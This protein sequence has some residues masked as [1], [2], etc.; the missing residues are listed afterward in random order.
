MKPIRILQVMTSMN[1]GGA[2]TYVMN[3]YRNINKQKV[4][5]DFVLHTDEEC[6]YN[7]EIRS[8]GGR[9]F[10]IPRYNG[11]NHFEYIKAWDTFF[12]E[13]S[14]YKVVHAH[15]RSTASIILKYAKK[16]NCITISHSHSSSN[17]KGIGA[18]YKSVLQKFIKYSADYKVACSKLAGDW[19]FGSKSN[20]DIWMNAIETSK[21][22]WNESTR[23]R[24]RKELEIP[25]NAFVIGHVG[26]FHPLK[27]HDFL[28]N[29]FKKVHDA[30]NNAILLLVGDGTLK[31][32]IVSKVKNLGLTSNVIFTGVRPDVSDLMQAMDVFVFP[33]LW[34][35]LGIV[36]IE[37]QAAGLKCIV[38]DTIPEEAFITELI[39]KLNLND[40][41]DNWATQILKY[42][43]GYKRENMY[44][45]IRLSGYDIYEN[46]EKVQAFYI[47]QY[48]IS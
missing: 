2:E 17:G 31:N 45:K 30:N 29:I 38:A 4:Q 8:L 33:S 43:H 19:L 41:L 37:A 35:G 10:T 48:Y 3:L 7:N 39:N 47:K 28:I 26:R 16:Y 23:K 44:E 14:E 27:N 20:Y 1:R 40:N 32:T 18:L 12:K 21:Y 13:H 24:I 9:I 46:V 6:A 5:F 36:T 22:L 15:I 42:S 25:K 34:E 11:L